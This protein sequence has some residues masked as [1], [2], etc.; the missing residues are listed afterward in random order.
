MTNKKIDKWDVSK[1]TDMASMFGEAIKFDVTNTTKK[2]AGYIELIKN[3]PRTNYELQRWLIDYQK[4]GDK[5]KYEHPNLWD[6][7]LITDMSE[8]FYNVNEDPN[9]LR[10]FNED[11]VLVMECIECTDMTRMGIAVVVVYN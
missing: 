6:V 9:G 4:N 10:D 3:Q 1:V 11:C 7:S 8:L 2:K 5:I